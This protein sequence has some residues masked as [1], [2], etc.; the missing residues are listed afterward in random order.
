[1]R[2]FLLSDITNTQ[3]TSIETWGSQGEDKQQ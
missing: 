3:G 2:A 1:M